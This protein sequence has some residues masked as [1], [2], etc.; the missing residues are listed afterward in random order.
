MFT[1]KQEGGRS[2]LGGVFVLLVGLML[3]DVLPNMLK[4]LYTQQSETLVFGYGVFA[5]SVMGFLLS[6]IGI[7]AIR[8]LPAFFET[9]TFGWRTREAYLSGE[10]KKEKTKKTD[11]KK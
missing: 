4:S 9:T 11:S 5:F 7:A 8:D 2:V 1:L 6:V 3:V 10:A